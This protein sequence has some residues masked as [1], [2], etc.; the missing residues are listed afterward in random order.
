MLILCCWSQTRNIMKTEIP[1]LASDL[2]AACGIAETCTLVRLQHTPFYLTLP[3]FEPWLCLALIALNVL[4]FS[5]VGSLFWSIHHCK[6][7]FDTMYS[8][9]FNP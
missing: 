3:F 5:Y 8:K 4:F 2:W 9:L 7:L 1:L 6:Q